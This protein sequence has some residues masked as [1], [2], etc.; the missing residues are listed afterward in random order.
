VLFRSRIRRLD[1]INCNDF[2]KKSLAE[3]QSINFPIQSTASDIKLCGI[4]AIKE[5]FIKDDVIIIGEVHDSILGIYNYDL[6]SGLNH[7]DVV[8]EITRLM[9]KPPL[10]D[11]FNINFP[12]PLTVSFEFDFWGNEQ[13]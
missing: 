13:K 6:V 3:R 8:E 5:H 4:Q 7:E 9:T 1:D 11:K 10:F 2:W 12:I